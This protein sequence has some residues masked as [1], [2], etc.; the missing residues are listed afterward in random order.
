MIRQL[1][2]LGVKSGYL[3]TAAAGSVVASVI[4]YALSRRSRGDDKGQSDRWGIFIGT[5][6]PTLFGAGV[7]LRLEEQESH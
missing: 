5:W 1:H 2:E 4:T 3:Y 6:A 7:A